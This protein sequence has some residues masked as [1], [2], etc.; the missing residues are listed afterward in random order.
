MSL[1]E[2]VIPSFNTDPPI[3]IE[4]ALTL[5]KGDPDKYAIRALY[6][7]ANL[8]SMVGFMLFLS[9][10]FLFQQPKV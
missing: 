4:E 8:L 10:V 7:I 3:T 9:I 2:T 5:V 6:L 1:Q